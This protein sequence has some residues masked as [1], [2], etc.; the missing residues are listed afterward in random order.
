MATRTYI[1]R[2]D[3]KG[4]SLTIVL[5]DAT[6]LERVIC[7]TSGAGRTAMARCLDVGLPSFRATCR[8]STA[9]EMGE[10][11][12]CSIAT[13]LIETICVTPLKTCYTGGSHPCAPVAQLDRAL[14]SG[15]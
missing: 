2:I 1:A 9:P 14:A 7:L 3:Q 11:G 5:S 4:A 6:P 15:A 12:Q 8:A 10:K 13:D